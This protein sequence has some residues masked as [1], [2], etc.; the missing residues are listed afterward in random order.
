MISASMN[1]ERQQHLLLHCEL[2][3]K[4]NYGPST[5]WCWIDVTNNKEAVLFIFERIGRKS[6][7]IEEVEDE[8]TLLI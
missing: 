2:H 6:G 1:A 7:R 4:G 3:L 8:Q 5:G